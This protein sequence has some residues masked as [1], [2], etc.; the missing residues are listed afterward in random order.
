MLPAPQELQNVS[1]QQKIPSP[2]AGVHQNE[3][4]VPPLLDMWLRRKKRE[5]R[6]GQSKFLELNTFIFVVSLFMYV[7][8][9]NIQ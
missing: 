8:L 2:S 7:P 3:M 6:N 4:V 1:V 5:I 9:S